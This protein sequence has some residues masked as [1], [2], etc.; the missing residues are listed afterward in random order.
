M[1][2]YLLLTEKCNLN[3]AMCIRGHQT[4]FS[5]SLP[6]L[7]NIIARGDFTNHNIVLTGGEPTMHPKFCQIVE[8]MSTVAKKITITTNGTSTYWINRIPRKDSVTIQV[9][10]DGAQQA[11]DSIRGTGTYQ[12][13][14]NTITTL[15]QEHIPYSVATVVNKRNQS[16]MDAL[17]NSLALLRNLRFWK[18]SYE[19]PFGSANFNNMMSINDWNMF[20]DHI[21]SHASFRL[22][23]KKL[24][25]FTLYDLHYNELI[26]KVSTYSRCFNCGSGNQKIY[27]YPNLNVYPCTCLTDFCV[28]NIEKTRLSQ[29]LAGEKLSPF[30]H[31]KIEKTS[32]CYPCKYKLFCNGGCIGMSYHYFGVLGKGDIR[33]PRLQV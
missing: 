33:C 25:P 8:M 23:I 27:I 5:L 6:T 28:G 17:C 13:T 15:D 3:C 9:S 32:P 16:S 11:H 24:F 1:Q 31:Y 26:K 18:L 7:K 4:G 22:L 2:I 29:I 12:K 30:S 19:M 20:V 21:I 14:W 10:L